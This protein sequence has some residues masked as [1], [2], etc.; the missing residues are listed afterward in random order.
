MPISAFLLAAALAAQPAAP[1]ADWRVLGT[2]QDGGVISYDHATISASGDA[3][4][5]HTRVARTSGILVLADL[6]VRCAAQ[7]AR[8]LNAHNFQ[9]DGTA[10]LQDDAASEWQAIEPGTFFDDLRIA[11]CPPPRQQ[12]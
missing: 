8:V 12:T 3:L 10:G 11:I 5:V 1:G 2:H 4:R 7:Q 6:E 9:P